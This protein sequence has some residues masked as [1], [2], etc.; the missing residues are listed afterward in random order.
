MILSFLAAKTFGVPRWLLAVL[1]IL[2][3][4]AL[5]MKLE[6]N[7][8]KNNQ[9][10]GATVER[11]AQTREVLERTETGN[12]VR[13]E[14]REAIRRDGGRSDIVYDQC[15]RTARTPSKCER[16]L[17]ERPEDQR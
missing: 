17:P 14:V 12:A 6:A 1:A 16:F 10:I 13:E 8:D 9:T 4:V 15:V 5:L 3:V 7:D 2:A 11:E